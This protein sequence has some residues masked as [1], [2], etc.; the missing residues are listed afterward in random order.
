[1]DARLVPLVIGQE[2]HANVTILEGLLQP[3]KSSGVWPS[4]ADGEGNLKQAD[5]VARNHCAGVAPR[6]RI[7]QFERTLHRDNVHYGCGL[8][9]AGAA[10]CSHQVRTVHTVVQNA[11]FAI[12][13]DAERIGEAEK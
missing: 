13:S 10:D 8:A 7:L 4:P 2:G 9:D 11:G 12:T 5:A 6:E 3:L 1:V